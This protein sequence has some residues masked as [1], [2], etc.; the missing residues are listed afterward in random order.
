MTIANVSVTSGTYMRRLCGLL[1]SENWLWLVLPV[2]LCAVLA[3][4]VDVR[5]VLVAMMTLFIIM[6]M[7]LAIIYFYYGL[8]PEARWSIMPKDVTIHDRD[9]ELAFADERMKK[10]VI[11]ADDV[12]YIIEKDDVLMLMLKGGRRYTC[13]M[14]PA[15]IVEPD[16]AEAVRQLTAQAH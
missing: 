7:V 9:I 12:R 16:I 2:A 14:L 6:P 11:P 4:W 3:I 5:F 1:L 10:H 15:S 13:L 8:S